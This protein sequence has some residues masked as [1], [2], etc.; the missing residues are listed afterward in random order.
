MKDNRSRLKC[1]CWDVNQTQPPG[2][3]LT[4][5]HI[6]LTAHISHVCLCD[7]TLL[8]DLERR[9]R[10][11]QTAPVGPLSVRGPSPHPGPFAAW[12]GAG[13]SARAP[14]PLLPL[15]PPFPQA[16]HAHSAP[17]VCI[18]RLLCLQHPS[19]GASRGWI[20]GRPFPGGPCSP[21]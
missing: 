21:L 5:C 7:R 13:S 16:L 6:S 1:G 20:W 19:P 17:R 8:R 2:K 14:L 3:Q 12:R 9:L 18:C 11:T 15:S 4:P 10:E